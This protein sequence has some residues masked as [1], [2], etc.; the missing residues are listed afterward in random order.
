MGHGNPFEEPQDD[1][2]V[3]DACIKQGVPVTP[4]VLDAAWGW[5]GDVEIILPIPEMGLAEEQRNALAAQV[6][7]DIIVEFGK[8]AAKWEDAPDETPVKEIAPD[9]VEKI[10]SLWRELAGCFAPVLNEMVPEVP[11]PLRERICSTMV[12]NM[13]ESF[14]VGEDEVREALRSDSSLRMS[15]RRQGIDPDTVH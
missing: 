3:I 11:D 1:L 4:A 7:D 8:A 9:E 15:L 5:F 14:E 6:I 13:A 2:R 10:D 12:E